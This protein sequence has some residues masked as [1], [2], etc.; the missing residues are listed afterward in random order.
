MRA[1]SE[2]PMTS[3]VSTEHERR[4]GDS[5]VSA[6]GGREAGALSGLDGAAANDL[7][8]PVCRSATTADHARGASSG[9]SRLEGAWAGT[10]ERAIAF[11]DRRA[12][13]RNG[14]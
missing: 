10:R 6:G 13:A 2:K 4:Q 14:R 11:R 3:S 9:E 8:D 1:Y 5:H 12:A 7:A